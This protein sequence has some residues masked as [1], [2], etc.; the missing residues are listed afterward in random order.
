MGVTGQQDIGSYYSYLPVYNVSSSTAQYQFGNTFYP[1]LRPN[2]YDANI[3]WETTTTSNVGLDFGFAD[4]RITGSID[5]YKK[6][7]KDLLSVV[8]VAPGSNFDITLL[9]NVGNM[10]NKGV[11]VT[12]NTIPL[13][14]EKM[15]W[16]LGFNVT[17][18]ETKITNL[19][20]NQD[21]LQGY[22]CFRNRWRYR[23]Y[24]WKV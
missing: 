18:N 3:R 20:R 21:P 7:T 2:A 1:F 17:Y 6:K 22:Q 9:T 23:K 5:V 19:L 14:S 13:K 11:E 16:S 4:S 12:V 24:N 15:I 8:P 10:E